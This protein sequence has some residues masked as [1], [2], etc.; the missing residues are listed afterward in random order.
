MEVTS[1]QT[2]QNMKVTGRMEKDMDKGFISSLM[3]G[4]ML[5]NSRMVQKTAKE[6]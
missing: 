2:N 5:V 3:I 1:S 4:N 6:L